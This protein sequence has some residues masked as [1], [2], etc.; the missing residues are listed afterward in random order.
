[1]IN[2]GPLYYRL[3][4]QSVYCTICSSTSREIQR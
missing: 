2:H 4:R 3:T 1:V